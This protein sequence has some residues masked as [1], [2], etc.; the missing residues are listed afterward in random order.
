[1]MYLIRTPP[2]ALLVFRAKPARSRRILRWLDR[3]RAHPR[4]LRA[5]HSVFTLRAAD[6]VSSRPPPSQSPPQRCTGRSFSPRR[7]SERP[8]LP[9]AAIKQARCLPSPHF[10]STPTLP[11]PGTR[12]C[13]SRAR[14]PHPPRRPGTARRE[15][16]GKELAEPSPASLPAHDRSKGRSPARRLPPLSQPLPA[17]L[18]EPRAQFRLPPPRSCRQAAPRRREEARRAIGDVLASSCPPKRSHPPVAPPSAP[19]RAATVRP[20]GLAYTG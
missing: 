7:R 15:P 9:R 2:F 20:P 3:R 14:S 12:R 18:H 10:P 1:M 17:L 19:P 6:K 8:T 11:L 4:L 5:S 16:A 13:D